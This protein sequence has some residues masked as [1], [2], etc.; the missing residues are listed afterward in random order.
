MTSYFDDASTQAFD[1][2]RGE[3]HK[4]ADGF[5]FLEQRVVFDCTVAA[6]LPGFPEDLRKAIHETVLRFSTDMLPVTALPADFETEAQHYRRVCAL[7]S[8]FHDVFHEFARWAGPGADSPTLGVRCIY[9]LGEE[10][11]EK[12]V[13]E[14][15]PAGGWLYGEP[16]EGAVLQVDRRVKR[17]PE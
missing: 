5:R 2:S 17:G 7:I 9:T 13:E 8:G 3:E 15:Y 16:P 4:M 14:G 1:I 10:E 11:R 12:M 6:M